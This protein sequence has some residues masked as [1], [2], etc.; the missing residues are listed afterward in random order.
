MC[1]SH[2]KHMHCKLPRHSNYCGMVLSVHLLNKY[3]WYWR[4]WWICVSHIL[5]KTQSWESCCC[6][7]L[8]WCLTFL[9]QS[10]S[11]WKAGGQSLW[12]NSWNNSLTWN[13]FISTQMNRFIRLISI[14]IKI[15]AGNTYQGFETG[16]RTDP[17]LYWY[18]QRGIKDYTHAD[19]KTNES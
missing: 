14:T 19:L 18:L 13:W 6:S 5:T 9:N 4:F 15:H 17:P 8:I 3:C 10:S 11:F 7:R 2:L 16:C 12:N 1:H